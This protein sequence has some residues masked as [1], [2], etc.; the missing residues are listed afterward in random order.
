MFNLAPPAQSGGPWTQTVLYNFCSAALC[1]DGQ[2]T[3]EALII[4]ERCSSWHL[5]HSRAA[6]G[7]RR[8]SIASAR[9]HTA[10]TESFPK[11]D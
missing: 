3:E 8:Y 11:L 5:R 4:M 9:L 6:P 2:N 10:R 7:H 1:T